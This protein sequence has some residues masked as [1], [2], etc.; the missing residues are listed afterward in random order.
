M[1]K[2]K[3]A[4]Q[5]QVSGEPD[6]FDE[7]IAAR[8]TEE[9]ARRQGA[10]PASA[11]AEGGHAGKVGK[12]EWKP[13]PDPHGTE[14]IAVGDN[15]VHLLKGMKDKAWLIRFDKSPNDGR[16]KE[17]PHP[18]LAYLKN[19][20]GYRWDRSKADGEMAWG[21]RWDG[22]SFTWQEHA[23]ARQVLQNAVEIL[24][25]EQGI[26]LDRGGPTP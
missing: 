7:Q 2:R 10:E 5:E 15:R 12:K 18:V 1:A 6:V 17:N 13:D 3:E 26:T 21:K 4:A 14:G 8:Q 25:A 24:A 20:A 16:S 9:A 23:D 22:D 11:T 19:E